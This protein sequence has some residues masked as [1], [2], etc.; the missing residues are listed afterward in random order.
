MSSLSGAAI[1]WGYELDRW[2]NPNLFNVPRR[3]VAPN[4]S[5]TQLIADVERL[6]PGLRVI[7]LPLH[8]EVGSAAIIGVRTQD[9]TADAASRLGFNQVFIDPVDGRILGTRDTERNALDPPHLLWTVQR[10]HQG[11]LVPDSKRWGLWLMGCVAI[12]WMF[13]A[14]IGLYL[15]LPIVRASTANPATAL[16]RMKHFAHRWKPSW[17]IAFGA[18]A[19]R[20]TLDT[21]RALALWFWLLIVTQAFTGAAQNLRREVLLPV[22][23]SLS[24]VTPGPFDALRPV[25]RPSIGMVDLT[26]RA[27]D[28]ARL[29]RWSLPLGSVLYTPGY[30]VYSA[31]FFPP[32]ADHTLSRGVVREDVRE[33]YFDGADGRVLGE[34]VPWRGTLADIVVQIRLPLHSARIYGRA[35]QIIPTILG[36]AT[37]TLTIAGILTWLRRRSP[38]IQAHRRAAATHSA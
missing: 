13:N 18:G 3:S 20:V 34:R 5:P 14:L 24:T 27:Q 11:L 1:S 32:G 21:H 25:P 38:R 2:L 6:A 37:A 15:T 31:R 36:L 33:L 19:A 30:G 4:R 12:A 9:P 26:A 7:S 17:R 35:G 23:R 8:Y 22:L 16:L 28:E 10:L 29:R